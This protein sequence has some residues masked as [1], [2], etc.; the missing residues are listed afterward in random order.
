MSNIIE[1]FFVATKFKTPQRL[2][3]S[4]FCL[5]AGLFLGYQKAKLQARLSDNEFV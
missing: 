5:S 1:S 3:I 4:L 2:G